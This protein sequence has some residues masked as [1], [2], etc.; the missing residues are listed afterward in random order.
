MDS[1]TPELLDMK[2]RLDVWRAQRK[3][4]RQALQDPYFFESA[5]IALDRAENL[6]RISPGWIG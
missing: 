4:I 5:R 3:H 2:A 6:T 1:V